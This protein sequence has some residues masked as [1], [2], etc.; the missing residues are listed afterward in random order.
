MPQ[1]TTTSL[2][3][4]APRTAAASPA[5][6]LRRTLAADATASGVLGLLLV[7][8]GG[9]LAPALGL[10]EA[11][12]RGAGALLLPFAALVA[13]LA[14]RPVPQRTAVWALVAG[15]ALWVV[16][17]V[18]VLVVGSGAPTALGIAFVVAQALA[19]VA[20]SDFEVMGLRRMGGAAR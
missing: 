11:L 19:V 16:A 14:S 17:S 1:P 8:A 6:F 12:L 18:L 5:S 20:L 9:T 15:N 4:S 10:P 7:A 3:S 2:V 13:M